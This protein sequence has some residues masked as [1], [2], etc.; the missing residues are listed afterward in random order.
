MVFL[1]LDLTAQR[2]RREIR[3]HPF[4]AAVSHTPTGRRL[5]CALTIRN[6]GNPDAAYS[7]AGESYLSSGTTGEVEAA[8]SDV[9]ATIVDPHD[10]RVAVIGIGDSHARTDRKRFRRGG[11]FIGIEN[12]TVTGYVADE[13]RTVPRCDLKL[14]G[15]TS[16]RN[17]LIWRR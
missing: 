4:R 8:A 9:W 11:Q 15:W 17:R 1:P 10:H 7:F 2:S 3:R 12:L 6:Y 16:R 14:A 5:A 13:S